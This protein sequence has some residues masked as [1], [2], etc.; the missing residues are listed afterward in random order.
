M[1]AAKAAW[2]VWGAGTVTEINLGVNERLSLAPP[3]MAV[4]IWKVVEDGR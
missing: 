4:T 1:K 2:M 3:F